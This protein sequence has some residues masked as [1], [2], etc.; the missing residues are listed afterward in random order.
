MDRLKKIN[1]G[2]AATNTFC[3][4]HGSVSRNH[5]EILFHNNDNIELI[6]LGS[7]YGTFLIREK[8]NQKV[9]QCKV[10]LADQIVFGQHEP[11]SLGE[12]VE[13]VMDV[14]QPASPVPEKNLDTDNQFEGSRIRCRHCK[15]VVVADWREC[16][17]CEGRLN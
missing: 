15:S 13:S 4:E 2:R 16:P 11:L 3:I 6:D 10:Q 1:I 8:E 7:T 14:T 17:F 12:I 9:D 5:A